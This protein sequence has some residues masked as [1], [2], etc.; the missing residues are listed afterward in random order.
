MIDV[1]P[2]APRGNFYRSPTNIGDIPEVEKKTS[3]VF[4]YSLRVTGSLL[5]L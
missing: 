5:T 1:F 2:Y 4:S 3:P